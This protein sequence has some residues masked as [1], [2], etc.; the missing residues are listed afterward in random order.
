MLDNSEIINL[1]DWL[2]EKYNNV[3]E[4]CDICNFKSVDLVYCGSCGRNI[5]NNHRLWLRDDVEWICSGKPCK[6][7][8]DNNCILHF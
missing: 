5:C 6:Q 1:R 8:D 3:S 7:F 2:V 4:Y